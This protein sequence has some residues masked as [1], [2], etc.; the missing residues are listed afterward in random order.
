MG[1]VINFLHYKITGEIHKLSEEEYLRDSI[2]ENQ[3]DYLRD[4]LES[5]NIEQDDYV[6]MEWRDDTENGKE[7]LENLLEMMYRLAEQE[8]GFDDETT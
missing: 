2:N 7:G 4:H 6:D 1:E 8:G 3:E 5:Q